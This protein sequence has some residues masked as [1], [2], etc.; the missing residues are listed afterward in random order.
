[1]QEM[2]IESEDL[3]AALRELHQ[4]VDITEEDLKKIYTIAVKHA[5]ERLAQKIP[6]REVMTEDVITV[7]RNV[8]IHEAA[9]LLSEHNI[10]GMPVVDE[11]NHV[12]GVISEADILYTTGMKK[13]HTFKD[14]LRHVLGEPLPRRRDRSLVEDIISS[15]A[16]TIKPDADIRE[17]ARIL[18]E[19]RI[20]RLPVVDDENRLV[21]IISRANIV[22]FMGKR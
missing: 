1:M 20:K 11:E 9:R 4:Y 19:K 15:P 16:I 3:Q 2:E 7:K 17:A 14:V 13:G 6:V 5:R 21:G 10:S 18:D 12:I 22:R 8:D